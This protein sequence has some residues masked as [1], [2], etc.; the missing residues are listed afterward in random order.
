GL[1][2]QR[3][4]VR[5]GRGGAA[6][7][8]PRGPP[9]RERRAGL[10]RRAAQP[11]RPRLRARDRRDVGGR[12]RARR[13]RGRAGARLHHER[14]R[15]RLLRLAVL[16]LR[17]ARGPAAEGPA[18]RP[19][20]AGGGARLRAGLARRGAGVHVLRRRGVPRGVPRRRLRRPARLVEP[21]RV[22]RLRRGLRALRGRAAERAAAAVPD[23]LRRRRGREGGA[24][25]ALRARGAAGRLAAGGG[26]RR[27]HGL[28]GRPEVV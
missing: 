16:L 18:P 24:R 27:R 11:E 9:G 8:H 28:A 2:Q 26:R 6:R 19:R 4:R 20:G 12:E 17:P 3:G 10:R 21:G 25:P 23:R 1:G 13:A 7:R 22:Q 15:G 14:A 5:A